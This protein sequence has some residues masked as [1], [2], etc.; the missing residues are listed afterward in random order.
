MLC[1]KMGFEA[2]V[3]FNTLQLNVTNCL[4]GIMQVLMIFALKL[5]LV[6][7]VLIL[8]KNILKLSSSLDPFGLGLRYN[9]MVRVQCCIVFAEKFHSTPRE[10]F[11]L[12]LTP[13]GNSV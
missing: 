13:L 4:F 5:V 2:G 1:L 7:L 10:G 8:R 11:V 9:S 12:I 3:I 6:K